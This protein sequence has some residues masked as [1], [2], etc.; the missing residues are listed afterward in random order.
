VGETLVVTFGLVVTVGAGVTVTV[1]FGLVVADGT[2]V[3]VTVTLGLALVVG[4][5]TV[6]PAK[7]NTSVSAIT[8]ANNFSFI[9]F[10]PA[11]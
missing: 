8:S 5:F 9:T 7:T 10:P 4:A 1:T 11:I 6:Q 2:G 3:V